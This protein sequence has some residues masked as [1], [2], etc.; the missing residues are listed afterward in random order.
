MEIFYL[1]YKEPKLLARLVDSLVASDVA[2][3]TDG[4]YEIFVLNNV[5]VYSD[6]RPDTLELP[7]SVTL[8]DNLYRPG[9]A[10]G[11]LTRD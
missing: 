8:L 6:D 3:V 7:D 2:H 1:L 5:G 11:H 10:K 9:F 4:S